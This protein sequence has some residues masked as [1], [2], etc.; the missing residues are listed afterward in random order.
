MEVFNQIFNRKIT[1][2]FQATFCAVF[3]DNQHVGIYAG[4]ADSYEKFSGVFNPIIRDYHGLEDGFEHKTDMSVAKIIGNVNPSAPIH[5]TRY[6]KF[7]R[8]CLLAYESL[9]NFTYSPSRQ[10]G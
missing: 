5:S 1:H 3:L 6:K 9:L 7:S 4:D 2:I 10:N 8:V